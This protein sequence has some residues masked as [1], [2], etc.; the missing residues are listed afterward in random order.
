M[1]CPPEIRMLL[2]EISLY[3]WDF[4]VLRGPNSHKLKLFS[5]NGIMRVSRSHFSRPFK[6]EGHEFAFDLSQ[7]PLRYIRI[8]FLDTWGASAFCHPAEV[9][10][11]GEV[12]D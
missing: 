1:V 9:D 4:P 11:Y 5:T 2:G 3:K 6:E 7:E 10:I 12:V 8:K